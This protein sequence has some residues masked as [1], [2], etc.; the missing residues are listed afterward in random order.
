MNRKRN[1]CMST[2]SIAY[3]FVIIGPIL[4]IINI[5]HIYVCLL[6]LICYLKSASSFFTFLYV[7][8]KY[9]QKNTFFF[10][11]ILKL[12]LKL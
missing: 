4:Y 5:V 11:C 12:L 8:I 9:Y 10:F 6:V 1:K 7:I 3:S 2:A